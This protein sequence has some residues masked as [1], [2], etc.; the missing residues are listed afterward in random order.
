[1]RGGLGDSMGRASK[2]QEGM[3]EKEENKK[4]LN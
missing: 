4:V 3:A 1:M 2:K